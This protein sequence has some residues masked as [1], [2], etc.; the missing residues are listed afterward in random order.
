[1]FDRGPVLP[2]VFGRMEKAF[3]PEKAHGFEGEILYELRNPRRA[4]ELDGAD[5]R[6]AVRWSGAA[7]HPL[8]RST[9]RTSVPDFV[10]LLAGES[11]APKQLIDGSLEVEGHYTL[12]SR[13]TEMFGG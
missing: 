7:A 6:S 9:F 12:A 8:R 4:S 11:F 3:V 10:R 5:R 2:L 1:M 13:M